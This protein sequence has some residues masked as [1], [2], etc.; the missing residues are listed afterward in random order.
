MFYG[1]LSLCRLSLYVAVPRFT[2]ISH[3][4]PILMLWCPIM[5]YDCIIVF[6][7]LCFK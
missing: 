3:E 5:C 7:F 6:T 4:Y 2:A 1:V